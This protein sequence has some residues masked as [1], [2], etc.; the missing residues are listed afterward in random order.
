MVIFVG[1]SVLGVF[2]AQTGFGL[3][4]PNLKAQELGSEKQ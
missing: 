1:P 3:I 4:H 2:D